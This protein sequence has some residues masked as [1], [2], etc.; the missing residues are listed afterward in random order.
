MAKQLLTNLKHGLHGSIQVPGDKSISHR[1]VMFG[2]VATGTT[3]ITGLLESADVKSTMAAFQAMGIQMAEQAGVWSIEGQGFN[4]L[5][6]P[7]HPLDMGNSGTST[8]LLLGLLAGQS[9]PL[10]FEGDAS[11]SR[12]PLRRVLTPLQTMGMT[13]VNETNVLPVTVATNALTGMTY[14]LPMASAQVKSAILLAGLQASGET[15]VIEPIATRDHTERMLRQFGVEV[16][17]AD[18]EITVQGGQKLVAT[19]I[20]VPGDMSSAAFWLTAGLL[21]PNTDIQIKHIGVN[22]TRIGLLR[23]FER[24][25]AKFA[26]LANDASVE[27]VMDLQVTTQSLKGINVTAEDIPGAVDEIPLLVLAATQAKGT[28]IITGAEELRVKESDRITAVTTE[29]NK[30]GAQ[31][32]E[33][34]DGFV[35][36][37]G[38]H[39]HVS[40][41]T[42]VDVYD[43]HR[44][45]M[46]LAI[47]GLITE[48]DVIL[49]DESVVD[50]SYPTFFD[51]LANLTNK[52]ER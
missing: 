18:H 11:L 39:L 6:E 37:G 26:P 9:F 48:G 2:S 33:R 38:T 36:H 1:A 13:L 15:T 42:T 5:T 32:E 14:E 50:I 51:D 27:P 29:L 20:A 21:V 49:A 30:L 12:R 8:R 45:G 7:T 25:G 10:T 22:T 28:T 47:A 24:M 17:V 3:T 35:I 31:I 23:L 43:D 52:L 16:Q 40:E 46:M 34:P 19:D 41:P 4:G 44:I